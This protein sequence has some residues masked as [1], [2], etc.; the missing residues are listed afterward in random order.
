[1]TRRSQSSHRWL[2]EHHNDPYVRRAHAEGWR[3]RA[4]YKLEEVD[5]KEQLL[6]R[7]GIVLDLGAAPGAWSQYARTRVGPKGR[8]VATD[9][10]PMDALAGVE[11]VQGDFRDEHICAQLIGLTGVRAVDAVLSDMAPDLSGMDVIDQPRAMY[12]SE[13]ALDLAGRVLK[14]GGGALI[15]VF[16]G[17]GFQELVVAARRQ[18]KTVRF[19]KPAASRARSAEIYLLASGLRLV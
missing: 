16:Q 2:Q 3:S 17:S 5:K 15:K 1:M 12:L 13:L 6:R 19:I 7:G 18:F 9:I 14:P 4:V 10:L 11:F 8:V